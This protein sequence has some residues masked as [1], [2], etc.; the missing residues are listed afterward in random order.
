MINFM[1]SVAVATIQISQNNDHKY[2]V[3]IMPNQS[4]HLLDGIRYGVLYL[5]QNIQIQKRY[6][7][8]PEGKWE[9]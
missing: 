1:Q 2:V 4:D 3:C 5:T 9:Q 7:D 8:I 6:D